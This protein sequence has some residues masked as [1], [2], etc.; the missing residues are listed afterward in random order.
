MTERKRWKRAAV[1]AV[2]LGVLN[3]LPTSAA[4]AETPSYQPR[5]VPKDTP[6]ISVG[7]TAF[8][9]PA[10][11]SVSVQGPFTVLSPPE[12]DLQMVV[13]DVKASNAKEAVDMVWQ[14]FEPG[15]RRTLHLREPSEPDEGW[16]RCEYFEYVAPTGTERFMRA[17]AREANGRWMVLLYQGSQATRAKR[18]PAIRSVLSS[19]R[20]RNYVPEIFAG[21]K[22]RAIDARTIAAMRDFVANGMRQLHIPGAAFSLIE[23]GKIVY[24]GGLGVRE[25]GRPGLVDQDTRFIAASDTKALTTLL[26]ARLVDEHKLR[27]DQPVNEVYSSFKFGDPAVTRRVQV[28]HMFCQCTGMPA[29]NYDSEFHNRSMTPDALIRLLGTM[30]P[31]APFGKQFIYSDL[32][33]AAMGFMAGGVAEPDKELGE[34]YEDAM[35]KEVL[36]PLGMR[37]STFDFTEAMQGNYARP[38]YDDVDGNTVVSPMT[39]TQSTGS[40]RPAGGLWTTAHDLSQYL[41]MELANGLLPNGRRLVSTANLLERRKPNIAISQDESYGMGLVVDTRWGIT[42]VDHAGGRPGYGSYLFWLPD[43]G[44]GAVIMTNADNG[45]FLLDPFARKL[46]ELVFNGQPLA[47]EQLR[48]EAVRNKINQR[49]LRDSIEIPPGRKVFEQLA[50]N[51]HND[52][53]GNIEVTRSGSN[54]EFRFDEWR[55]P[56]GARANGN[57]TTTFITLNDE[58]S[59]AEFLAG[60]QGNKRTLTLSDG[61]IKYIFV[62][63]GRR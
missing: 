55:S 61:Q 59:G 63:N 52:A 42:M 20:P 60:M 36:D 23:H 35:R 6:G 15:S 40:R 38:H 62:E 9:I 12:H 4:L 28:R 57:G 14:Q 3:A 46:I 18:Q 44:I 31:V 43:Y 56:I 13:T 54:L 47:G 17:F 53:L 39:Y 48:V 26:I 10:G 29:Q 2:L 50:S 1:F 34:A 30:R 45:A 49:A 11:W 58:M 5:V 25:L 33:P 51:Y 21:K 37:R 16:G 7:G 8:T 19:L 32:L 27:W 41:M 22:P 24:E